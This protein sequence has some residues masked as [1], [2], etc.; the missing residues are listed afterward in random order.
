MHVCAS[1]CMCVDVCMVS[2]CVSICAPLRSVAA[3][4]RIHGQ[5]TRPEGHGK[6]RSSEHAERPNADN[7]LVF[8]VDPACPCGSLGAIPVWWGM[9]DRKCV[10]KLVYK[11]ATRAHLVHSIRKQVGDMFEAAPSLGDGQRLY[12][13]RPSCAQHVPA[14]GLFHRVAFEDNASQGETTT[15]GPGP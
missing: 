15:R 6:P 9:T 10:T 11:S 5:G 8:V 4:G 13:M 7:T 14:V 1:V 2:V 12:V 3:T